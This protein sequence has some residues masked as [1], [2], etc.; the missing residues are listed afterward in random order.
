MIKRLKTKFI[1]LSMT[2]LLILLLII[3]AGMNLINYNS[4]CKDADEI[5]SLISQNKGVFPANDRRRN[6]RLPPGMSPELP[7]ESRYFSVLL[8]EE[9]DVIHAETSRIISVDAR[10]A[11]EYAKNIMDKNTNRGFIHDYRFVQSVEGN[12]MRVTFLDCGRQLNAFYHF[13]YIS[14]CMA[15]AGFVLVFFIISFFAG[16]IIV[17]ITESYEK[18]KRFITDAGHEIKTPLT[19]INANVDILEMDM[20]KNECLEDI[21]QQTKRLAS[22]TNDLVYLAR[23]EE[24]GASFPM[25]EFPVSEIMQEAAM[26]F[27]TLAKN[28]NKRFSCDVQ[29]M[30]SMR[31]NDAAITQ[32]ISL[33]MDNAMKY[34]PEG[35]TISLNFMKQ[36]RT[37]SLTVFNTTESYVD[38]ADLKYVFDRFYRT[39]RSRNSETGGHGI[40]L[41]IA[42]A[43]V[44]AHGGKIHAHT[45]DG[46][47]F[48][49]TI[50]FPYTQ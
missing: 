6:G 9:G 32:L 5:L 45:D 42:K 26:P 1:I 16:K 31:G 48:C 23:M 50:T 11:V 18:Q 43:I 12:A 41:S 44:T 38:P 28:Q 17:P 37:L 39:D 46:R 10:T 47:S 2:S 21:Q 3:I 35:G 24:H 30:L 49:L 7:Y 34:S 19:I 8:N 40:G 27:K 14:I 36:N 29:P 4:V 20:G 13:L 22:L 15:L 25:I 33:L